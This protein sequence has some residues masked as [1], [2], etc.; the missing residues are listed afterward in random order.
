MHVKVGLF[1]LFAGISALRADP[2]VQVSF[3]P[4]AQLFSAD[5]SITGLRL[6]LPC[7]DN[8]DMNG[9]DVGFISETSSDACA[10]Q[11]EVFGNFV[12]ENCD[13]AQIGLF[14][15]V[16]RNMNGIQVA[17][18]FNS[19]GLQYGI[20]VAGLMNRFTEQGNGIHVA[21]LC[22]YGAVSSGMQISVCNIGTYASGLQIGVINWA[23]RVQGI[24]IGLI[25][26]IEDGALPFFPGINAN[27]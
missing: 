22:N 15:S 7:S 24:Q 8:V 21:G 12:E 14:N 2:F 27:F 18:L 26:Y 6:S 9:I 20:S 11:V 23:K 13:G 3:V 17:G 4:G 5:E 19:D 10:V 25:N 16:D 1:V